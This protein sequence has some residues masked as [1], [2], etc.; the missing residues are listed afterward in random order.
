LNALVDGTVLKGCF[1]VVSR[2]AREVQVLTQV[3][4]NS[5]AEKLSERNQRFKLNGNVV[6]SEQWDDS[7]W[8]RI[9]VAHSFP[10]K[11]SGKGNKRTVMHLSYQ[12]SLLGGGVI[13]DAGRQEPALHVCLWPGALDFDEGQCVSFPLF[14][15]DQDQFEVVDGRLLAW[16]M[17]PQKIGWSSFSWSYS[18]RL[19]DLNSMDDVESH[20]VNPALKLMQGVNVSSALPGS[21]KGL[22]FYTSQ[23]FGFADESSGVQSY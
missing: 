10:L 6:L 23:E 12:I 11:E 15:E 7:R 17:D 9:G 21:L 22:V 2:C 13:G 5:I 1:S 4:D 3:L 18:I 8:L 16:G 14:R 19:A 20:V